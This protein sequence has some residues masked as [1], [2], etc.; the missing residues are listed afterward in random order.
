MQ[1]MA[2]YLVPY[3]MRNSMRLEDLSRFVMDF[4]T[5]AEI[6]QMMARLLGYS[7]EVNHVNSRYR[8]VIT[9]IQV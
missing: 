1:I 8:I 3:M 6:R 7:R 9:G 4:L 5:T 2:K